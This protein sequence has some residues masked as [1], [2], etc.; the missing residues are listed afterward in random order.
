MYNIVTINCFE[1]RMS[2]TREGLR[3]VNTTNGGCAG[4][5]GGKIWCQL[6]KDFFF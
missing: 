1:D 5:G 6:E 4:K 3:A 2:V